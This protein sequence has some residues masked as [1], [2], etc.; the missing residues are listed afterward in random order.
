MKRLTLLRHAKSSWR[1][2]DLPDLA[3]PLSRRGERDAPLMGRR[4]KHRELRPS[5]ILTSHARRAQATARLVARAL[6]YPEEIIEV[7]RS[8][9]LASPERILAV[10]AAQDERFADIL[11]VAHNPG[12]TELVNR[13]LP[14]LALDNLP[15]CGVV[16]VDF[17]ADRWGDLE[18]AAP[19]LAFYDS[20]KSPEPEPAGLAGE[21]T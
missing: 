3:R 7:E 16:A 20:P 17:D 11:L 4:L 6:G 10:V 14:G 5:L 18:R 2:A 12:L 1:E 15:T 21:P 9:Y 8:L 13:L 19:H